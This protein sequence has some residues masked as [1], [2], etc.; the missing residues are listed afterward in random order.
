MDILG[1]DIS[2]EDFH[3]A[4]LQGD[5]AAKKSFPNS[6]KGFA[7]L[8]AWLRNRRVSEVLAC[9]ES[10]GAYWRALADHLFKA[11]HQVRVVNP[12]RIKAFAEVELSRNKTDAGDALLIAHFAAAHRTRPYQ[13]LAPEILELQ[14]LVR[15]LEFLKKVRTQ[16]ITRVQ[17][18]GLPSSVVTSTQKIIAEL[19]SQIEDIERAIKDHIDRHPGIRTNKDLLVSIPAIGLKTAAGIL[20]EIPTITEFASAQAVAAYAGLSPKLRESGTS[21]R[22]R[23]RLCKTGSARLRNLLY[24]PAI[25][26]QRHN[27]TLRSF[28]ERLRSAGKAKMVIIGAIMRKLLILAYGVL[29]SR[30]PY[31][32][33]FMAQPA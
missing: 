8:E 5:H 24:M 10:T 29:K 21:V 22:G 23:S 11:G 17:T 16:H 4:L 9:M 1:I 14:G 12:R 31:D 33:A 18:P 28:A 20:A 32:P 25:V 27:P 6:S 26:A 19:E 2:K 13:P 3:A 7:Q 30:Q 15:H